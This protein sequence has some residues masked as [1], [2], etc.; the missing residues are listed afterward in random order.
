ML[1]EKIILNS[2]EVKIKLFI[3]VIHEYFLG[4]LG[5]SYY[6]SIKLFLVHS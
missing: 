6:K 2:D 3:E 4:N 1:E 5:S